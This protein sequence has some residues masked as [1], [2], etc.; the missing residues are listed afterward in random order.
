MKKAIF[1]IVFVA[2]SVLC[3]S[4]CQ[5]DEAPDNQNQGESSTRERLDSCRH[6]ER[7]IGCHANGN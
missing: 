4:S 1:M 5:A 3:F 7:Q 6:R 2:I